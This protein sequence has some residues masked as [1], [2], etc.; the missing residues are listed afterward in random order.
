MSANM[1]H[2]TIHELQEDLYCVA[3]DLLGHGRRSVDSQGDYSIAAQAQRVL[4]LADHLGLN[5]F[6]II[7]H[8]MGGQIA[9]LI[10]SQLA[11]ERV[12]KL[13]HVDGVVSGK[14]A[15]SATQ[16]FKLLQIVS[17]TPFASLLE[18]FGRFA[19]IH[20]KLIARQF[21]GDWW[22]NFGTHE[23]DWWRR[24]REMTMR[25]GIHHIWKTS[26]Q[27]I[28]ATDMTPHLAAISCP[29]LVIFG[30]N[31]AIIPVSEAYILKRHIANCQLEVLANCGHLPMYE[32]TTDYLALL[33][34]F[35]QE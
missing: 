27:A 10:A 17:G 33:N 19:A 13:V 14:V 6:R 24:D 29:T 11:P 4:A 15:P 23:F 25:Q 5:K 31:D 28:Y 34:A 2:T 7:G 18:S 1:W 20:N 12:A 9:L 30:E 3:L 21:Y 8:S 22:F 26:I 16:T 32:R 35:L